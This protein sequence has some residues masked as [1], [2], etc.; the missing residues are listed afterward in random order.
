MV[1]TNLSSYKNTVISGQDQ[2]FENEAFRAG[3]DGLQRRIRC[4]GGKSY[5][6]FIGKYN[7]LGQKCYPESC[8]VDKKFHANSDDS[9]CDKVNEIIQNIYTVGCMT[10]VEKIYERDLDSG[11][12]V[13]AVGIVVT[14]LAG[15]V[16]VALSSF[17][18]GQLSRRAKKYEM[19]QG[20]HFQYQD[21]TLPMQEL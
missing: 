21:S 11:L 13:F 16:G 7:Q 19:S 12:L 18:V 5:T 20:T 14:S 2:Y 10:I 9:K 17:F 1:T 3:W 15:L 6:D 4:C 8:F